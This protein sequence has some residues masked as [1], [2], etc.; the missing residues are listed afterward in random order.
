MVS[1]VFISASVAPGS[2]LAPGRPVGFD[3]KAAE[4]AGGAAPAEACTSENV[5]TRLKKD[6]KT[7]DRIAL[8]SRS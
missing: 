6:R 2:A 3:F 8:L 5:D 4:L 7:F 1:T